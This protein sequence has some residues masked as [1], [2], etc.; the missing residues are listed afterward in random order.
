MLCNMLCWWSLIQDSQWNLLWVGNG[1][2]LA[3]PLVPHV[4]SLR[5]FQFPGHSSEDNSHHPVHTV[6]GLD[7]LGTPWEWCG[8]SQ[9]SDS[10]TPNTA[11]QFITYFLGTKDKITQGPLILKYILSLQNVHQVVQV[12]WRNMKSFISLYLMCCFPESIL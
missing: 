6:W 9:G 11:F 2:L 7:M 5:D 10:S 4:V 1:W 8:V 12:L 3:S